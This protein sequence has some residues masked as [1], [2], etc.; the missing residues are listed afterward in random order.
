MFQEN[1]S[2]TCSRGS[3]SSPRRVYLIGPKPNWKEPTKRTRVKT[4]RMLFDKSSSK[5]SLPKIQLSVCEVTQK[6]P[7]KIVAPMPMPVAHST[8]KTFLEKVPYNSQHIW[9]WVILLKGDTSSRHL[10]VHLPSR[11]AANIWRQEPITTVKEEIWKKCVVSDH[12]SFFVLSSPEQG[13][14]GWYLTQKCRSS[15]P[16]QFRSRR[17]GN[18]SLS[19]KRC[20]FF[21]CSIF[22]VLRPDLAFLFLLQ[23]DWKKF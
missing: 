20:T 15:R 11:S 2:A 22:L 19:W 7:E 4:T 8:R 1:S 14:K 9:C 21:F 10:V 23:P 16:W 13:S 5:F 17:V 6:I 18:R 12:L 3:N